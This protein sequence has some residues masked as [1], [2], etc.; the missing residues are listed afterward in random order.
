M[1]LRMKEVARRTGLGKSAI[2][3]GMKDGS[4]PRPI[5]LGTAPHSAVGWLDTEITAWLKARLED[6]N[7][8]FKLPGFAVHSSETATPANG[9]PL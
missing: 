6:R 4:F 7:K 3:A 2:Y 5:K 8:R 1:I 9:E